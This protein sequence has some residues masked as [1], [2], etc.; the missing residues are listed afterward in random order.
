[1]TQH[2]TQS[3]HT[4][5]HIID[6]VCSSEHDNLLY[7]TE[8]HDL[9][10]D[11]CAV[12]FGLHLKKSP[13]R[14][15]TITYRKYRAIDR[16]LLKDDITSALSLESANLS[17]DYLVDNYNRTLREIVDH[18]APEKSKLVTVRPLVPWY[19]DALRV[20]K[21]KRRKAEKLWKRTRLP[22]HREAL[23]KSK[24]QV[25]EL[26]TS[27]KHAYYREKIDNSNSIHNLF[28][29]V[30]EIL[31]TARE[32]VYPRC[33]SYVELTSRF[34]GYFHT[35][36]HTI[37]AAFP[38]EDDEIVT[39]NEFGE[40]IPPFEQFIPTDVEE[41]LGTISSSSKSTCNLDPIPTALLK[42]CAVQIAPCIVEIVNSSLASGI[43]PSSLK[44][45]LVKPL[46][47][48]PRLDKEE[49]SNY[50]PIP[51]LPL[52]SR[53]IERIVM[54]RLNDHLQR[55]DLHE[56]MQSAYKR[57]HSTET[58]LIRVHS[59][60]IRDIDQKNGVIL[61]LLDLSSAFDTIDHTILIQ[62]L[63]SYGVKGSALN[64][65]RSYLTSRT[66]RVFIQN[67]VSQVT[68][69]PYGVPQG[70]ILGPILFI[71]Y[72]KPIAD[73]CRQQGVCVHLYADDTQLYLPY[74]V[75]DPADAERAISQM[76][77]CL[78]AVKTWMTRNKLK[79]NE[80]KTEILNITSPYY[81]HS[82]LVQSLKIGDVT[83]NT[84]SN[85]RNIGV[86]FDSTLSMSN[87]IS[88]ICR[89]AYFHLKNIRAIRQV[90]TQSETEKL[91]H[92][93]VSSRLD[94]NNALLYGIPLNTLAPLQRVQNTAA[95]IITGQS[96]YT[97]ITPVLCGLHWLPIYYRIRYK[98]AIVVYKALHDHAP[99]YITDLVTVHSPARALRSSQENYLNVPVTRTKLGDRA[100]SSAAPSVWNQLPAQI[101]NSSSL[102]VFKTKLKLHFFH[103]AYY[104]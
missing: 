52:L 99:P 89:S 70:S 56:T 3:T 19:H 58:A 51:N 101:R 27:L 57:L 42:E 30:G 78:L 97:H 83:V 68:S 7:N 103:Q 62:R 94:L 20:A 82:N 31:H 59:D 10:T 77:S 36:V 6:L 45:A 28:S 65:F 18:H 5:G 61:V 104:M 2:V 54:S 16:N 22:E 14:R 84:S 25:N 88:A 47:K 13:H 43:F 11:H 23:R 98:I 53:V 71:L 92:A 66:Q 1:M 102:S 55:N 69:I 74:K 26:I 80:D 64:W 100:Y 72:T 87:H 8:V 9:L 75:T 90:L 39:A 12:H 95:R 37:R 91:V 76:E 93:F 34:A 49:M 21:L 86:V 79:L 63:Q 32:P 50:R 48:K 73:I 38:T 17:V 4:N 46:L 41:V 44:T 60:I 33:E 96:K 15:Q 40:S 67:E 85:A 35:K 81:K 24:L 29:V